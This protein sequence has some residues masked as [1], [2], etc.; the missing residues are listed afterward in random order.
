MCWH[1]A[2]SFAE[3]TCK[4]GGQTSWMFISNN[5]LFGQQES[6]RIKYSS[7]ETSTV[8]LV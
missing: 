4:H 7:F 8:K 3:F 6:K 1:G 2:A 5:F